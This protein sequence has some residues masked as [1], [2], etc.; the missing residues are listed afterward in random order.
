[1]HGGSEL[2][3]YARSLFR[4]RGNVAEGAKTGFSGGF[5]FSSVLLLAW[6]VL[7]CCRFFPRFFFARSLVPPTVERDLK[8]KW[9]SALWESEQSVEFIK[10]FLRVGRR[11]EFEG[12]WKQRWE[13]W[14]EQ[15]TTK[16]R[17]LMISSATFT[18][19]KKTLS[20]GLSYDRLNESRWFPSPISCVHVTSTE[21]NKNSTP[22]PV[23]SQSTRL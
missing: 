17:T 12:N 22:I 18:L 9:K 11:R 15:L 21:K 4:S 5:F 2:Q 14:L 6:H 13:F 3:S 23:F 20:P 16:A 19:L 8:F 7:L 10:T 1:M